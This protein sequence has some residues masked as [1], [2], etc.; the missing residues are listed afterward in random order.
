MLVSYFEAAIDAPVRQLAPT[1]TSEESNRDSKQKSEVKHICGELPTFEAFAAKIGVSNQSLW[2]WGNRHPAFAEARAR[3]KDIQLR[4]LVDRGLTRQYDATA[5]TFVA[6]N[7]LGWRDKTEVETVVAQDT[8]DMA[9]MRQ[10]LAGASA[11]QL[12]QFAT[13]IAAMQSQA[14]K[15]E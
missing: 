4:I 11:E 10:T 13:L 1:V 12:A 6:K 14:S 9:S 5:F 3:A 2:M 7:M 15:E 8:S